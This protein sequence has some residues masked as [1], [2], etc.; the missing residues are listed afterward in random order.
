MAFNINA[1]VVLSGPKNITKVRNSI[2][3]QLSNITVP[4][5]VKLDKSA[6]AGLAGIDKKL[7]NLNTNLSRLNTT[8]KSTSRQL[9]TLA[10]AGKQVSVT[11]TKIGSATSKINKNLKDT[12]NQSKAAA[13]SIRDFG[14]ESAKAIRKF[15]AFTIATTAVFGFIRSV[16]QATSEA[17]RFERELV[18]ITQ[19]TGAAGKQLSGLKNTIDDIST[20]LGL[21]ANKLLEVSRIFAQTG[22]S[23]DQVQKS[24]KAVSRA[25][26]APTFGDIERTTEGL[27]AA[28]NQFNI[29]ANKSEAILGSLNAVAKK[30][31]VE[32]DDLISVIRRA[33][34]VF[35]A[36]SQQLGA[37]E[38]RLR[39]L[40]GI[41]TA[42][43]STTRESA[44]SI[45]TGLRTIFT[46]IQRPQTI[47]FLQQFGI[48]LR[49]TAED[50]K[51]LGIV[52]GE[53][54]GIFEALKRISQ[55]TRGL[56]TLSLAKVVE[57]LGGIRQVGKL[58]PALQNFEKA[59]KARR[60]ALEGTASISKDV[61]LA[62]QTLSVQIEKLQQ[63]FGKLVRDVSQSATFQ[64][65]A[66]FAISAAN[67][68]ITLG[69]SL[70]PIIP[71]LT[72]F[73]GIKIA[74]G[75]FEFG[76]GFVGG[77]KGV[78]AAGAGKGVSG[79][80]TGQGGAAATANQKQLI[81]SITKNTTALSQNTSALSKLDSSIGTLR[82]STSSL[83]SSSGQLI[84][85][86]GRLIS[87]IS[88]L[89]QRISSIPLGG[90]AR[91][92]RKFKDG[93][94]VSGPSH[95]QGGVVA[96]LE[97]GEF[98]V[99][100][101]DVR[102][103]FPA[104]GRV[105]KRQKLATAGQALSEKGKL[106]SEFK[107]FIFGEKKLK[108]EDFEKLNSN[109]KQ[110]LIDKFEAKGKA[111]A[112][113]GPNLGREQ[114][115]ILATASPTTTSQLG[116]LII[117]QTG[118][119]RLLGQGQVVNNN[120]ARAALA[121][122][123]GIVSNDKDTY[124]LK[125]SGGGFPVFNLK[126]K[127]DVAS[128]VSLN[129]E[130][131][132]AA[133]TGLEAAIKSIYDSDLVES[134]TLPPID[135]QDRRGFNIDDEF[136]EQRP[137]FEGAILEGFARA[138]AN[139]KAPPDGSAFD[140]QNLEQTQKRRLQEVL[141]PEFG[142][143]SAIKGLE[144]KRSIS[145]AN[146]GDNKFANKVPRVDFVTPTYTFEKETKKKA[147]G[148]RI[149]LN[150]GG[151]V[152]V[153]I[154]N[155]EAVVPADFAN[156]NLN[157]LDR[158]NKGSGAAL[159]E[160]ARRAP[161][162]KVVGPGTGT[163]DSIKTTLNDGDFVIRASSVA[164]LESRE[165]TAA[166][167]GRITS[168]GLKMRGGGIAS[169]AFSA[170]KSD[171]TTAL[172]LGFQG[173]LLASSKSA[174]E[175]SANLQSTIFSLL[176]L[177]PQI[178][179]F[180]SQLLKGT[181]AAVKNT[182]A[183]SV[184]QRL[185][186]RAN[187]RAAAIKA[188]GPLTRRTGLTLPPKAKFG[189]ASA[190]DILKRAR[191][192]GA[193]GKGLLGAPKTL[194]ARLANPKLLGKNIVKGLGGPVGITALIAGLLGDPIIDGITT[195][196]VGAKKEIQGGIK[197]FA[198]DQGGATTAGLT[199]G[200][201]GAVGGAASG[202]GI[203]L[204]IAPLFGP[205]GPIAVLITTALGAAIGA[206]QGT[207]DALVEQAKFDALSKLN[208]SAE[209]LDS[210]LDKL[211]N[212][213]ID[214]IN[215]LEGVIKS[216]KTL[217]SSFSSTVKR[218]DQLTG[219]GR[220]AAAGADPIR[221]AS[222]LDIV[223]NAVFGGTETESTFF[224]QA[225]AI[226]DNIAALGTSFGGLG[227]IV[228]N[229]ASL[230]NPLLALQNISKAG[231]IISGKGVIETLSGETAAQRQT[232]RAGF[233]Q[234]QAAA[235]NVQVS[236]AGISDETIKKAEE[237]STRLTQALLSGLSDEQ[238][239]KLIADDVDSFDE[240]AKALNNAS[241]ESDAFK[242]QLEALTNLRATKALGELKK[243]SDSYTTQISAATELGRT[244]LARE[245]KVFS[246]S[247]ALAGAKFVEGVEKGD[248]EG[249]EKSAREEFIRNLRSQQ[250]EG[251]DPR[252]SF[253]NLF[254]KGQKG[255]DAYFAAVKAAEEGSAN[256]SAKVKL[257]AQSIQGAD[258]DA[259]AAEAS[260]I[261]ST[262]QLNNLI[263]SVED[264]GVSTELAAK[265]QQIYSKILALSAAKVDALGVALNRFSSG[266]AAAVD[267]FSITLSNVQSS[268]AGITS[269]QQDIT[270][271]Q[272]GNIFNN[273]SG[274]SLTDL[275]SGIAR[276]QS[277]L[278]NLNA[279][280][281]AET[282]KVGQ[283]IGPALKDTVDG[284]ITSSDAIT[285]QKFEEELLANLDTS[286]ASDVAKK[287]IQEFLERVFSGNRQDES[288]GLPRIQELLQ[289]GGLD[290][291]I[292]I[293]GEASSALAKV[294]E[295]LNTLE[296]G[297]L[298]AANLLVAASREITDAQLKSL[299]RREQIEDRFS[300]F[301]VGGPDPL[302]QAIQ[303][304][305][306]QV[307]T[308]L[309]QGGGP[310]I[311]AVGGPQGLLDRRKNLEDQIKALNDSIGQ[312]LQVD[313]SD[314]TELLSDTTKQ[315]S[316]RLAE[317]TS[318]LEGTKK[319]IDI[320]ANDTRVLSSI[321]NKLTSV[322]EQRLTQRQRTQAALSR[323]DSAK[324]P[325][326][327]NN[328]LKEI[329]KPLIAAQKVLSNKIITPGEAAA[330][331]QDLANKQG[332]VATAFR[333]QEAQRLGIRPEEVSE[334]SVN[335]FLEKAAAKL[336][337]GAANFFTRIAG[338]DGDSLTGGAT[339]AGAT[340][341]GTTGIEQSLLSK[342]KQIL[343][344]QTKLIEENGKRN[345]ELIRNREA[346]LQQ[347]LAQTTEKVKE[348]VAEFNK[349][350]DTIRE[351]S[352]SQQELNQK[353]KVADA[354]SKVEIAQK[355]KQEADAVVKRQNKFGG[356]SPEVRK[357]ALKKQEEANKKLKEANARLEK[358]EKMAE[359][360][361]KQGSIYT[362]DV[363]LEKIL[364]GFEQTMQKGNSTIEG[365]LQKS[366][367]ASKL[368]K[369]LSAPNVDSRDVGSNVFETAAITAL[370]GLQGIS[371]IVAPI[372][373][374]AVIEDPEGL[375]NRLEK[376]KKR[377]N[378]EGKP[379]FPEK[380][381]RQTSVGDILSD[382]SVNRSVRKKLA[383]EVESRTDKP[384]P[385]KMQETVQ[386]LKQYFD[387]VS[388]GVTPL[389]QPVAALPQTIAGLY[390][391]KNDKVIR[392]FNQ[393]LEFDKSESR[394]K[395]AERIRQENDRIFA[396]AELE[397][398][399]EF[400]NKSFEQ[401]KEAIDEA[402]KKRTEARRKK[403]EQQTADF[404]KSKSGGP[405]SPF[406]LLVAA[407]SEF[408]TSSEERKR[409]KELQEQAKKTEQQEAKKRSKILLLDKF[410]QSGTVGSNA[411][412]QELASI[413][414]DI[415]LEQREIRKK[416]DDSLSKEVN[417][418]QKK[419]AP[420]GIFSV[421]GT[422]GEEIL[423][424]DVSIGLP[425]GFEDRFAEGELDVIKE[426]RDRALKGESTNSTR[427]L[428]S[429]GG[430]F[431]KGRRGLPEFSD[432]VKGNV[433]RINQLKA[434]REALLEKSRQ[435][436]AEKDKE[437]EKRISGPADDAAFKGPEVKLPETEKDIRKFFVGIFESEK[438][439]RRVDEFQRTQKQLQKFESNLKKG[440]EESD[441]F[442][443]AISSSITKLSVGERLQKAKIADIKRSGPSKEFLKKQG[444]EGETPIIPSFTGGPT[445]LRQK[446][447][448]AGNA[449][450]PRQRVDSRGNIV[451][452][453][454]GAVSREEGKKAAFEF[455]K[456]ESKG[457]PGFEILNDDLTKPEVPPEPRPPV[458]AIPGI[459]GGPLGGGVT[460]PPKT[461]RMPML[462]GAQGATTLPEGV[463]QAAQ[464]TINAS[465]VTLN[466]QNVN[467]GNN[468]A[469]NQSPIQL[470]NQPTANTNAPNMQASIAAMT[471][472]GDKFAQT[473]QQLNNTTIKIEATNIGPIDVNVNGVEI[474]NTAKTAF[475]QEFIPVLKQEIAS[476][477]QGSANS[478][479]GPTS[480]AGT[481]G[482]MLA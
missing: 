422:I 266:V 326:E 72:A 40:I 165:Q 374:N 335:E 325:E 149:G 405:V 236:L 357:E 171:P 174:E 148:G 298:Q 403:L 265:K 237:Q 97:G 34:G 301:T 130:F 368:D 321:E 262:A 384:K 250:R 98:V 393:G 224:G 24:L 101:K 293:S 117:S 167:G 208:L 47:K 246:G 419:A 259:S 31:A 443:D 96:E 33:G 1:A 297:I 129:D 56:D 444:Q 81:S 467:F 64:S 59:E 15:S 267:E 228:T 36:S 204:L 156:K 120:N 132:R 275:E 342:Q 240:L 143:A 46:R 407:G 399:P 401:R 163:S 365:V 455:L 435:E 315:N 189:A 157:V 74:R 70:K 89:S 194:A 292:K 115:N 100:K 27:I 159:D 255:I 379:L 294:T 55:G 205:A 195:A 346:L 396:K 424:D 343:D 432:N 137:A 114:R 451:D 122:A 173:S 356:V 234:T 54:I 295:G 279:D 119:G 376:D 6:T 428:Q 50:A 252:N 277:S 65:L 124:R 162:E 67:A 99:P 302:Q 421:L 481:N 394:G 150:T 214:N 118:S 338:P 287:Q 340:V 400:K 330:L 199:G 207:A 380:K 80:L 30:F 230:A 235:Q 411:A 13:S 26:L 431:T 332:L 251:I 107:K 264:S 388:L 466:A 87:S 309:A 170:V 37:P 409:T 155:G 231:D 177:G 215:A 179:D 220:F 415:A 133:N 280:D 349:L 442:D 271:V 12:A 322:Q 8:A 172:L 473:V 213:A 102:Q 188:K 202:A 75:A 373:E 387:T 317:L 221:I 348:S 197:G 135:F 232:A 182:K 456:G 437:F 474:L 482:T 79:V 470:L 319:A 430:A 402:A 446:I 381:E 127:S 7:S 333:R 347:S 249:A 305:R 248:T 123:A 181:K 457:V 390:T 257:F 337:E 66:K 261:K 78:G 63:R 43:R 260:L 178:K 110:S 244:D 331:A 276:I 323:L 460:R 68:F 48:Q 212:S 274:A 307:D 461:T 478:I 439:R 151:K 283:D 398:D 4:V 268:I 351:L 362:H 186:E 308:A 193:S 290:D 216:S 17:I 367:T 312:T 382:E 464:M 209:K 21:D 420:K 146:S 418:R 52:E 69:E 448:A 116:A 447:A 377:T 206:I 476:A 227:A 106:T 413:D 375:K 233:S 217:N 139:I 313:P 336:Q 358:V 345:A 281:L 53:F 299:D 416:F 438:D 83:N 459:S 247:L 196:F 278:G 76:K 291:L 289:Q 45:A 426:V 180:G 32:S 222:G 145:A 23:L 140:L 109:E 369:D 383:E 450:G 131:E 475:M 412:S 355:E 112:G 73:A 91:P 35:A 82:Q 468:A 449:K 225:E 125:G 434:E 201:K 344:A 469:A 477:I 200:L 427:D 386:N 57:E 44:D 440:K 270:P 184:A 29:S 354:R 176:F 395:E 425:V 28:L 329:F 108:K 454:K 14:V 93:G 352:E 243:I 304:T 11:S 339:G 445:K 154:S 223:G 242:K 152:D 185:T 138:I 378:Q 253:E 164:S 128:D 147:S 479:D 465:T 269:I 303:R 16:Q 103:G 414:A 175:F 286:G 453:P 310:N 218:L 210:S 241:I 92:I 350:R 160:V 441:E 86:S 121:I 229:I 111:A 126:S 62:T 361:T 328:A 3:K 300:K 433:E 61:A 113:I 136:R 49:A 324:T 389:A 90:G 410:K 314:Q 191:F 18:K 141:D 452:V 38:E 5:K 169:A 334:Q 311:A 192:V 472:F 187:K 245:L 371:P 254:G 2:Q 364:I 60:V 239:L 9:T 166:S 284:L 42:V 258:E 392:E 19:V 85:E 408:F 363:T 385:T 397:K 366:I 39:E 282:I 51:R 22:Q 158:A 20:G 263:G 341:A 423:G 183:L 272:R 142:A 436:Q 238:A 285:P 153:A 273:V 190:D 105:Y 480:V 88:R 306:S 404:E 168:G 203:G 71:L 320:L 462:G 84:K 370:Q 77:L 360:A 391:N 198:K 406:E 10:S 359:N 25:S 417:K 296:S 353:F 463:R 288:L 256:A 134:N 226:T 41:F 144:A 211:Q 372:L 316:A 429:K 94:F 161:I 219:S 58:I 95:A 327:R 318:Q 458:S 471:T 104:G